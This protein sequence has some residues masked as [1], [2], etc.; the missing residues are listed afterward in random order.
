[1]KVLIYNY[2]QSNEQGT[3]GGGVSV[4]LKGLVSGLTAKGHE[5]IMLSSGDRYSFFSSSPHLRFYKDDIDR[6]VIF[7]SPVAAPAQTSFYHLAQRNE[8]K[9]LD[10]IAL[11]LKD[12][13][14]HIDVIHFHNLEGLTRSFLTAIRAAF[15]DSVV[16]Y[17]AHNYN[18]I[19]PQVNLWK[20]N[21]ESC[22]DFHLGR[23]CTTCLPFDDHRA[24][25]VL[26]KRLFT[27]I[28]TAVQIQIPLARAVERGT[29]KAFENWRQRKK[30][31][32]ATLE[33]PRTTSTQGRNVDFLA[34]RE[35]N[36][37]A[38]LHDFDAVLAVSKRTLKILEANGVPEKKLELS[39]IG[40]KHHS[41]LANSKRILDF[42][43]KLQIAYLGYAR[44]DKGFYFFL[45]CLEALPNDIAATICLTI[46]AKITDDTSGGR[47]ERLAS[48]F[49]SLEVHDGFNHQNMDE[50]LRNVNLGVVPV[51]WED[52]L[53]QIAIE[54]VCRGIPILT[55]DRGGAQEISNSEDFVF[56]AESI[57]TFNRKIE[58]INSGQ[59]KAAR[60]WEQSPN[61]RSI[62]THIDEL[63]GIYA[64]R[65]ANVRAFP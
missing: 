34:Y 59:L 28:K 42:T 1:M 33:R 54:L 57:S 15:Q 7:N 52:N 2:A 65:I 10:S 24:K 31:A 51:I 21:S 49:L 61:L 30:V 62:E 19:C 50:I 14:G 29:R 64:S 55:S 44:H 47:I 58:Q 6:A 46:A 17:T 12:R 39:Y 9:S 20:N 23:D 27:P 38:T 36:I 60:F 41:R 45:D 48:K 8:D 22:T 35:L 63:L 25:Q 5:V 18:L 40:S 11:K 32:L 37:E 4:Y 56:P 26:L 13:Y 3:A 43:P 16:L 53:P